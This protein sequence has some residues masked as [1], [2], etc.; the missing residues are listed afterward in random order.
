MTLVHG[1]RIDVDMQHLRLAPKL[2]T[3][4]GMEGK[5]VANHKRT[6]DENKQVELRTLR[7]VSPAAGTIGV[8]GQ[9]FGL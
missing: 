7:N 4:A 2:T 6:K 1:D 3:T 9:A 8:E 5:G